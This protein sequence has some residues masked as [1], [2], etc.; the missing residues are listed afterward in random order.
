MKTLIY[1]TAFTLAVAFTIPA[2]AKSP[3]DTKV[4]HLGNSAAI[5]NYA[6]FPGATHKFNVYVQGEA[7][8]ELRIDL[9]EDIKIKQGIEVQNQSGKRIPTTVDI[10][11]RKATLT[12]SEPIAAGNSILVM[13]NGIKTPGYQKTWHYPV[14][15]KKV[16]MTEEIPLSLARV[17]TYGS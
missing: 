5:P 16:G 2:F 3:N 8:S 10:N 13:M 15:I 6:Q 7:I 11:A 12:F 4:T 1:T 17:Q 14:Y 9:P